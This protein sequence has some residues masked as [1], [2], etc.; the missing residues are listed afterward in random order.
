MKKGTQEVHFEKV[1]SRTI[2]VFI[3]ED[4]FD[5][6]YQKKGYPLMFAYGLPLE[7]IDGITDVFEIAWA[8]FEE[9]EEM[10]D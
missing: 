8:N 9:Y 4:C 10:F 5:V 2:Y 1:G 3:E 7:T 6:Y